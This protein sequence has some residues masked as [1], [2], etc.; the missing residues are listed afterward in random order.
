MSD[1]LIVEQAELRGFKT[2]VQVLIAG[3]R[4]VNAEVLIQSAIDPYRPEKKSDVVRPEKKRDLSTDLAIEILAKVAA[5]LL[6]AWIRASVCFHTA[7]RARRFINGWR[8]HQ[9]PTYLGWICST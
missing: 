3:L 2:H 9:I 1:S 7:P 4:D 5:E 6:L 8:V